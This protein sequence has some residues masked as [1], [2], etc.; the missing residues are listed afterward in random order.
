MKK[1]TVFLLALFVSFAAFAQDA[2]SVEQAT[3]VIEGYWRCVGNGDLEDIKNYATDSMIKLGK[4]LNEKLN[5]N[6]KNEL[7]QFKILEV[8]EIEKSNR[9]FSCFLRHNITFLKNPIRFGLTTENGMW[10]VR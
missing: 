3:R 8:L 2:P 1:I 9:G 5:E 7:K 4:I 6:Q 10:K